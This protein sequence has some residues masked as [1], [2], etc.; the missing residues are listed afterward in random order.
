MVNDG[1]APWNISLFLAGP[2]VVWPALRLRTTPLLL[3]VVL[4][5]L[6]GDALLPTPFGF[7]TTLFALGAGTVAVVRPAL[8]RAGR[9]QQLLLAWL[10]NAIYY[11]IFTLWTAAH[12][13]EYSVSFLERLAVDFGLSQ[14][15][16]LPV[17]LWFFDLQESMLRLVRL[18][19]AQE[20][21]GSR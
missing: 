14:F 4:S 7:L 18:P 1:L 8:G 13:V 9:P 20:L 3:C 21:A 5:G 12:G 19:V 16:L 15:I 10:L 6:A 2:C 17:G 11:A